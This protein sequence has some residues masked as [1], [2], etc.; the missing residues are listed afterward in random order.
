MYWDTNREHV[1][2]KRCLVFCSFN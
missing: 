2:K 1:I